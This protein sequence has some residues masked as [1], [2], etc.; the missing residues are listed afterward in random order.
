MKKVPVTIIAFF[1]ALL[2][3]LP[4]AADRDEDRYDILDEE[5]EEDRR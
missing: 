3:P 4:S 2:T 5:R 1:A